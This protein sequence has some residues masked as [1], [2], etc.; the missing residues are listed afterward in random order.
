MLRDTT[1][2][3]ATVTSNLTLM[4]LRRILIKNTLLES[5]PILRLYVILLTYIT[6]CQLH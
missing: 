1:N 3:S 2:V 4:H 6:Q 5:Q